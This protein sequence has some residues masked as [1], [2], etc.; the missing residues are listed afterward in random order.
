MKQSAKITILYL[1]SAALLLLLAQAFLPFDG[2]VRDAVILA[3]SGVVL[4]RLI[5]VELHRRDA[6]ERTLRVQATHDPLTGLANRAFFED[7]LQRASARAARGGHPFGVAYIDLDDFKAINDQHGHHIGDLLLQEVACRIASV[8][9]ASDCAARFGGDE[10]VVLIDDDK[11]LSA[12]RLADRLRDAFSK[13][14][15]T[16][17]LSL[18][19]SASIGVA[20]YSEPGRQGINLLQ[21]ADKAMYAAKAARKSRS[22]SLLSDAA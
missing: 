6:V 14:F 5:S 11:E 17:P 10:F 21:A 4:F 7:N 8:V 16:G 13:P 3:V 19:V 9:R 2:L 12:Y 15:V 18:V 22:V 20:F 1:A